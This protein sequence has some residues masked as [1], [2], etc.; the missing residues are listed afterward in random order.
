M[1][2]LLIIALAALSSWLFYDRYD[3]QKQITQLK[4]KDS[5]TQSELEKTKKTGDMAIAELAKFSPERAALLS[6]LNNQEMT[7]RQQDDMLKQKQAE[8]DR[9]AK[10]KTWLQ[11]EIDRRGDPLSPKPT[12]PTGRR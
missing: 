11:E 3:L 12:T 6:K 2:V 8:L 5:G 10:K 4:D 9:L 1:R 7:L